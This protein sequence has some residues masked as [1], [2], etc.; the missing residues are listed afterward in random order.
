M[1]IDNN[2][3]KEVDAYLCAQPPETRRA[4]EE[5]R[6]Y[7][8]L[9]APNASEL[10]NYSI[11]AYALADGGKRDQQIMIAGYAST[12]IEHTHAHAAPLAW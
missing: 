10:L 4:L 3:S 8:W 9:A 6:S 1:G 11:P 12:G 7:I 5:L 2:R